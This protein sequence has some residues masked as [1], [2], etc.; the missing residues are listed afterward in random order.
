MNAVKRSSRLE[1]SLAILLKS[2]SGVRVT[3]E[4]KNDTEVTGVVDEVDDGMNVILAD[5]FLIVANVIL[6][7]GWKALN[8]P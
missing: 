7:M 4:L 5:A 8:F 3:V 6:F 2:L 1:K